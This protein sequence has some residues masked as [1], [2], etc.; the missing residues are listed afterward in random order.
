MP[1]FQIPDGPTTIEGSRSA[2]ATAVYSI[3]N[4][5]ADSREGRLSV[6]PSGNSK[7][8]WFSIEGNRE[9]TFAAGETQTVT[10]SAKFP[11]AAPQG[12]Y[13]FR[14]RVVGVN[15][16]DND[17]AEGA[18][19]VATLG[20]ITD[21]GPKFKWWWALV[22]LI[23][24]AAVGGLVYHLMHQ[25]KPPPPPPPKHEQP[26][27][28]SKPAPPAQ[29]APMDTAK[30]MELAQKKTVE[31]QDAYN[32]KDVDKL[33]KLSEPPFQFGGSALLLSE[34]QIHDQYEGIFSTAAQ[35]AAKKL[36]FD[37][38]KS[39]QISEYLASFDPPG[40]PPRPKSLAPFWQ[41]LNLNG[42]DICV[43]AMSRGETY[44]FYFRRVQNDVQLAIVMGPDLPTV[45]R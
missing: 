24:V 31:W 33:V 30:A 15:D 25:D 10:V 13:P 38:I 1:S 7:G 11:A 44:L 29:P 8:E 41:R 39:Q 4:T 17:H 28:Q 19:T 16:P 36:L 26:K 12:D 27:P 2:T 21:A 18:I 35:P 23:A 40:T 37:N 45:P 6:V 5:S 14:L 42:D 34:A 3:T 22:A 20:P 43:I 9:R 32:A